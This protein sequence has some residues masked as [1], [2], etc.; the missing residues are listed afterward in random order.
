[1]PAA[2]PTPA[3]ELSSTQRRVLVALCRPYRGGNRFAA[4]ATDD[5]IAEDLIV[6]LGEVRTHL[7]ILCAKLSIG[8]PSAQN[9]RVR[10]AEAAFAGG[11]VTEG[12]L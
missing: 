6:S 11:Y 1:V 8:D 7:R 10:L 9:A 4:P 2:A 12:D 3:I 5:Q